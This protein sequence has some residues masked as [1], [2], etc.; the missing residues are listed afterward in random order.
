VA[1]ASLVVEE[2]V[3]VVAPMS[4][5]GLPWAAMGEG[6]RPVRC[7]VPSPERVEAEVQLRDL[8]ALAGRSFGR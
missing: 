1:A 4:R 7:M 8:V 6:R 5:A 3:P 2:V